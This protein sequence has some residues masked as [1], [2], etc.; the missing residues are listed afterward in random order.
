M[1]DPGDLY[2]DPILTNFSVGFEAQDLHGL[3]I[4][5]ETPV[6]TQSGKYNVF[7]RSN[8]VMH[9][10]RRE[11]GAVAN[12]I[13]GRKWS[14]DV[15]ET[16]EHS[17][18][19]PIHDEERQALTSLGG[20]ADPTFG[21]SVQIDPEQDATELVTRSL[22]LAHE[23]K[24]ADTLRN[25]ANYPAANKVTLAGSQQWN[26]YTFVTAGDPYSIVSDPVGIIQAAMRVIWTATRRYP[27]MLVIPSMGVPIIENH[28]RIVNR[29]KNFSLLEPDAFRA[30]TGF[31]GTILTVDS[32]YNAANNIDA[33][34]SITSFWG[35]DVWLGIVDQTP[36]LMTK[37]F[38]KTFS[39][40]YPNGT[41]RPTDRWREEN[42]KSDIVRT[43]WKWDTKIVSPEAG[44]L[45][46][47][48]FASGA[49]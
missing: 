42:R 2:V 35:K 1:Y 38:A 45:I 7:D 29:Y 46:T 31:T 11:P 27:N 13:R 30:L 22:M 19:S 15:F 48:A 3:R 25:A 18:Q 47:N 43:S 8:W 9:D 39:Q 12:E 34:E 44:Y 28:P 37:T 5:P 14:T 33:T 20:L 23:K 36:G 6:R 40:I 24:V 32:V 21:G 41:T 17:L 4:F 16:Q 10:S 26:D 49:F